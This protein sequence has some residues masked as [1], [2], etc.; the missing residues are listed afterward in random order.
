MA[1]ELSSGR[2]PRGRRGSEVIAIAILLTAGRYDQ[3]IMLMVLGTKLKGRA[4]AREKNSKSPEIWVNPLETRVHFVMRL[5]AY[6]LISVRWSLFWWQWNGDDGRECI[7]FSQK[8][9]TASSK[10]TCSYFA[11]SR[12]KIAMCC[13]LFIQMSRVLNVNGLIQSKR[14][15]ALHMWQQ[16]HMLYAR[17]LIYIAQ[18]RCCCCRYSYCIHRC[19]FKPKS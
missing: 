8:L 4:R 14:T 2:E 3:T 10:A 12:F 6:F 9:H 7:L 18:R 19:S 16:A 13:N 15:H 17:T 1:L 11:F 5:G